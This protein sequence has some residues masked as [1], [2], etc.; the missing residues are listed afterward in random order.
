[1]PAPEAEQGRIRVQRPVIICTSVGGGVFGESLLY[2]F[3]RLGVRADQESV[4]P[5]SAYW[6]QKASRFPW[7]LR[8]RMYVWYPLRT[9]FSA[10]FSRRSTYIATTNPFF[11]PWLLAIVARFR[12]HLVVQWL[13]DLYPDALVVGGGL[14]E[15]SFGTAVL[16][17]LTGWTLRMCHS[18]VF[19]GR[20][21]AEYAQTRYG[22]VR[23]PVCIPVGS[24]AAPFSATAPLAA[25]GP[26]I[27]VLYSGHF[28]LM[29]DVDT[30]IA[31]F[32]QTA[33]LGEETGEDVPRI[34]FTFRANGPGMQRLKGLLDE[35]RGSYRGALRREDGTA[36]A[37]ITVDLG[38]NL[39]EKEWVATMLTHQVALV[40]M[41][42]GAERVVMP[43]KTYSALL[44]GQAVLGICP[45]K[46]DLADVLTENHCGWSVEPG[47]LSQL[48]GALRELV[49][50]PAIL[51]EYR[52]NARRVAHARF[53]MDVLA[54]DWARLIQSL[55][56]N[57]PLP[58]VS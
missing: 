32:R 49:L 10:L 1:M 26:M 47:S 37:R 56:A 44:A 18:T 17:K 24:D 8:F 23:M 5:L 6:R 30:L 3:R 27:R 15:K 16:A 4:V 45:E 9:T 48:V 7:L 33:E 20:H 53:S 51:A 39:E 46:S 35:M 43:S 40:T 41:R 54:V 19:L 52:E 12:G 21:L 58:C 31:F 36:L 34:E 50:R 28:G 11:L 29:H 2:S 13:Y 38:G 42:P 55:E 14:R 57:A 25:P 22:P